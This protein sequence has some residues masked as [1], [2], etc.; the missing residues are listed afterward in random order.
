MKQLSKARRSAPQS[1]RLI[2]KVVTEQLQGRIY[3]NSDNGG[4][5]WIL[6]EFRSTLLG[7]VQSGLQ[8][9]TKEHKHSLIWPTGFG[10][11]LGSRDT[12]CGG[13]AVLLV[14]GYTYSHPVLQRRKFGTFA[15]TT[16]STRWSKMRAATRP[17]V[18]ERGI[19]VVNEC[20]VVGYSRVHALHR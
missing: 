8:R 2:W 1:R 9:K 18:N 13:M 5:K 14:V 3:V 15:A 11:R 16:G 7:L 10:T 20:G 6:C 4:G 19:T 17:Y 12:G